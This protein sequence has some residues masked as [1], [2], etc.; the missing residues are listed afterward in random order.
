M[1]SAMQNF[2]KKNLD[3]KEDFCSNMLGSN[4]DVCS[5]IL[6]VIKVFVQIFWVQSK[7]FVQHSGCK[8]RLLLGAKQDFCSKFLDAKKDFCSNIL[9]AK[10]HF[11][12]TYL[13]QCKTF[14]LIFWV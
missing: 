11:V 8:A 12:Q 14:R 7:N 3:A 6:G 9:S 2:C 13:V 5:N 4:Q 1:L 10:Q